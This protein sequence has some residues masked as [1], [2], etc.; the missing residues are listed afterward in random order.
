MSDVWTYRDT[1]GSDLG[2][3]DL[4]GY[5]VHATDG[6]IGTVDRHSIEVGRNYLVVDTGFWIF[7]KKRVV[8]AGVVNLVDHAN[9]KVHVAMTKDQIKSAPDF[10]DTDRKYGDSDYEQFG[11]YYRDYGFW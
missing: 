3:R 4:T 5:D 6:D 8:P 7:G 11:A 9:K 2:T 10:E 1:V